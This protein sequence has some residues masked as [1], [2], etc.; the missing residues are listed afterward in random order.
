MQNKLPNP[1][2]L[3]FDH[4]AEE[5]NALAD[6]CIVEWTA[7]LDSII[8]LEGDRTFANTIEP[9]AKFEYN[10]GRIGNNLNFYKHMSTSKELRDASL[11]ASKKFDDWGIEQDM[12]YDFFEAIKNFKT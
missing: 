2:S 9:L 6:S 3:R 7:T 8:K 5:I 4:T 12:R 10:S 11:A 1:N